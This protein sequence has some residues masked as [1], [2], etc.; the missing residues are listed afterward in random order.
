MKV[1]RK[2]LSSSAGKDHSKKKGLFDENQR[3]SS[4]SQLAKLYLQINTR[5]I[6]AKQ[7]LPHYKTRKISCIIQVVI[8]HF[9]QHCGDQSTESLIILLIII[10]PDN[11]TLL[12]IR[13][14]TFQQ[15]KEIEIG[16]FFLF[17]FGK[18]LVFL[19]LLTI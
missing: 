4:I 5:K 8:W 1:L 10:I 3:D 17:F 11:K 6:K 15:P 9:S 7:Q 2:F 19:L 12:S 18:K 13:P 14:W 16:F